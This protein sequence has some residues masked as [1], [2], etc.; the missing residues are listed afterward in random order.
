MY[1]ALVK[2]RNKKNS[3]QLCTL[4]WRPTGWIK[5][6]IRIQFPTAFSNCGVHYR[7]FLIF[8]P[9]LYYSKKRIPSI[10]GFM[11]NFGG[12]TP[13]QRVNGKAG[14]VYI[15]SVGKRVITHTYQ[16]IVPFHIG[17]LADRFFNGL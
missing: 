11:T 17:P 8:V 1:H 16:R 9:K 15:L 2:I 10:L 12:K 13:L 6:E 4:I 5:G 14:H 3:C 7:F